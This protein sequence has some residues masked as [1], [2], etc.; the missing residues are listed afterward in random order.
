M[1][2]GIELQEMV[3]NAPELTGKISNIFHIHNA[4]KVKAIVDLETGKNF[5][6]QFMGEEILLNYNDYYLIVYKDGKVNSNVELS[7]EA[8]M[9]IANLIT[10]S[11]IMV[12][13]LS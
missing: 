11:Y 4:E 12:S 6:W 1:N 5:N 13:K 9:K 2:K 3:D 7:Q 8:I 10:K